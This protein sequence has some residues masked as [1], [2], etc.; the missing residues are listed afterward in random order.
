[1]AFRNHLM[2]NI[3]PVFVCNLSPRSVKR[4]GLGN[5]LNWSAHDA[6]AYSSLTILC[7]GTI[8][9]NRSSYRVEMIIRNIDT[10][11]RRL[12]CVVVLLLHYV[13]FLIISVSDGSIKCLRVRSWLFTKHPTHLF[14]SLISAITQFP[15]CQ[16]ETEMRTRALWLRW[17]CCAFAWVTTLFSNYR[18]RRRIGLLKH[19]YSQQIKTK[20]GL[21]AVVETYPIWHGQLE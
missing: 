21:L 19:F 11:H 8:N 3:W 15:V 20:T 10:D 13:L 4:L 1:M 14:W 12:Y 9:H 7:I 18:L 17:G 2:A 5:R 6:L 16:P